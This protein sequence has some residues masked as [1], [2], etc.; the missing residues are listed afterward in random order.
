MAQL[1]TNYQNN[2]STALKKTIVL[3]LILSFL[4]Q[5]LPVQAQAFDITKFF[6]KLFKNIKIPEEIRLTD[7]G[8][9]TLGTFTLFRCIDKDIITKQCVSPFAKIEIGQSQ[10]PIQD[11]EG[12]LMVPKIKAPDVCEIKIPEPSGFGEDR[13][14]K[15]EKA[16]IFTACSLFHS[17]QQSAANQVFASKKIFNNTDPF[18]NCLFLRNCKSSCKLSLGK[19]SYT[20]SLFDIAIMIAG[21]L[22][23]AQTIKKIAD[24]AV[25]VKELL[26]IVKSFREVV[27]QGVSLVKDILKSTVYLSTFFSSLNTLLEIEPASFKDLFGTFSENLMAFGQSKS[28][29]LSQ[30]QGRQEEATNLINFL[31]QEKG[32]EFLFKDT[33]DSQVKREQLRRLVNSF[34]A[35]TEDIDNL[36]FRLRQQT[37]MVEK[38]N[39]PESDTICQEEPSEPCRI[40][41]PLPTGCFIEKDENND[42]RLIKCPKATYNVSGDKEKITSEENTNYR[43]SCLIT[44]GT[45]ACPEATC[46]LNYGRLFGLQDFRCPEISSIPIKISCPSKCTITCISPKNNWYSSFQGIA[47][48]AKYWK[49]IVEKYKG[50]LTI[51]S[52]IGSNNEQKK[53]AKNCFNSPKDPQLSISKSPHIISL[54]KDFQQQLSQQASQIPSF[55]VEGMQE[56]YFWDKTEKTVIVNSFKEAEQKG[57][58]I[59]HYNHHL[60]YFLWD[61]IIDNIG[62]TNFQDIKD[63]FSSFLLLLEL[64]DLSAPEALIF[65]TT[66]L[67]TPQI[68]FQLS[69]INILLQ[70]LKQTEEIIGLEEKNKELISIFESLNK[71]LT[72]NV[73][74]TT[75][76]YIKQVT[77][78]KWACQEILNIIPESE[79]LYNKAIQTFDPSEEALKKTKKIV[80][81]KIK[82]IASNTLAQIQDIETNIGQS[83][84]KIITP[85]LLIEILDSVKKNLDDLEKEVEKIEPTL[86]IEVGNDIEKLLENIKKNPMS[87][88]EGHFN[89]S[90]KYINKMKASLAYGIEKLV[91]KLTEPVTREIARQKLKKLRDN[92]FIIGK[93]ING[94]EKTR[95][96]CEA[97]S[98]LSKVSKDEIESRYQSIKEN[99]VLRDNKL[100]EKC[101]GR[102]WI[103]SLL[104]KVNLKIEDLKDKLDQGEDIQDFWIKEVCGKPPVNPTKEK[105]EMEEWNKCMKTPI[106][107]EIIIELAQKELKE[108]CIIMEQ[109][110][111]IEEDYAN[112]ETIMSVLQNR[113]FLSISPCNSLKISFLELSKYCPSWKKD[114][115]VL[116]V[117]PD[118]SIDNDPDEPGTQ[119][120][121]IEEANRV[122]STQLSD[123]KTPLTKVMQVFSLLLGI[124]SGTLAYKGIKTSVEDFKRISKSIKA[125]KKVITELPESL[126]KSYTS[127]GGS[128]LSVEAIKCIDKP[129]T[130]YN[131]ISGPKGGPVCPDIDNLFSIVQ[132]E[133]NLMRQNLAKL[134]L[135]TKEKKWWKVKLGSLKLSFLKTYPNYNGGTGLYFETV[136]N[137]YEKAKEI[138]ERSQDLWGIAVAINF[139]SQNCTCGQSYCKLPLCISGLPLTLAPLS[140]PYC[141]IVYI[142]R[143]PFLKQIKVL[144]NYLK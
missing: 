13:L 107:P 43:P 58:Q 81:E 25:K 46:E 72:R 59:C 79:N 140:N 78:I 64:K 137:L 65:L 141:Y 82:S 16:S 97:V 92:I 121:K 125:F 71:E 104:A 130:G 114:I 135:L 6:T 112:F 111:D 26:N 40:I 113:C 115:P 44:G 21:P 68:N 18:S 1:L 103:D 30:I 77:H 10:T 94:G 5:S 128:G 54:I 142:V 23:F 70:D 51:Y 31:K 8:D 101:S 61:E 86:D 12:R 57:K 67:S 120:E 55:T 36:I 48:N 139:A 90:E 95:K 108:N 144:E 84:E 28:E 17:I 138:K 93:G 98:F 123:L 4:I 87:Q 134:Y 73:V 38:L 62:Q 56:S 119:N 105:S 52:H 75:S 39:T 53:Y 9:V 47:Q 27:T 88:I 136:K 45:M 63:I 33:E 133:F 89:E 80:L 76:D 42:V 129:A 7:R 102:Y 37:E 124:K 96:A 3:S 116:S 34:I 83:M 109:Q 35:K 14:T 66:F 117:L 2:M 126:K 122:C 60:Q 41:S 99:Y 29:I 85:L 50:C 127:S 69:D 110:K 22:G 49:D 106:V 15:K 74:S 131:N 20:I 132:S 143:L 32:V 19:I 24:L 118:L 100:K 11:K 91:D